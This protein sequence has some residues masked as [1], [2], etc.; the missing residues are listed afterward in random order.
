MSVAATEARYEEIRRCREAE[1]QV[2]ALAGLLKEWCLYTG[3]R[4]RILES[5]DESEFETGRDLLMRTD[6]A[7]ASSRPSGSDG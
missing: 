4:G 3:L 5:E 7:L 2:A 6:E 1:A